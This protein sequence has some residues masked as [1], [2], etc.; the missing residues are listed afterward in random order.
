MENPRNNTPAPQKANFVR[1]PGMGADDDMEL[2]SKSNQLDRLATDEE[3]L[4]VG[5]LDEDNEDE[6]VV[7]DKEH[8]ND[9]EGEL[10]N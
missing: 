6:E 1:K 3:E 10:Q 7:G 4:S 5:Y 2:E 9:V 8:G